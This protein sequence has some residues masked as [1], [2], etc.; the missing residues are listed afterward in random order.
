MAVKFDYYRAVNLELDSS[1]QRKEECIVG[2]SSAVE[3]WRLVLGRRRM[4]PHHGGEG[5]DETWRLILS[6]KKERHPNIY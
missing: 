6:S 2:N 5:R 1:C 4:R 3:E